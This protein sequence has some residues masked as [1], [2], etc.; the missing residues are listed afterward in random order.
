M[1]IDFYIGTGDGLPVLIMT[2]RDGSGN[3][4]NLS[5]PLPDSITLTMRQEGYP[6]P[7]V[8][9]AA[10]ALVTDGTDGRVKYAWSGDDT[11]Q[12]GLYLAR[13]KVTYSGQSVQFPNDG[14]ALVSVN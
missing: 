4:V 2:L 12:R 8:D 6:E 7:T 14:F 11:L 5:N 13:A 10:M 3:I 9:D 1:T